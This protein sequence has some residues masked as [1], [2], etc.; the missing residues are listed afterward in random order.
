MLQEHLGGHAGKTHLD[1]MAIAWI[2]EK[3]LA[4]SFLDIGC[5]TGGM[6]EYATSQGLDAV[7]IDGDH[8]LKRFDDSKFI[9]HDFTNGPCPLSKQ[10]DFGWSCEF[11]EHVYEKYIPNYIQSFQ[12][13]KVVMITYAPPGWVGHHHVNCQE[14]YYWIDKF[15]GYGL[16]YRKDWTEELR[17][18]SSMNTKKGNATEKS[19]V[20]NRGLIFQ[21]VAR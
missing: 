9:L 13:C 21:N 17:K 11:V 7:G 10:Y 16:E 14:E 12:N 1:K 5:G 8:T 3:F 15:K 6:V 20:K 19:F 18:I 2:K 4:K